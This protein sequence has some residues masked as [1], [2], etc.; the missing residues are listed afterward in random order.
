MGAADL[1]GDEV[2]RVLNFWWTIESLN[3]SEIPKLDAKKH[4]RAIRSEEDWPWKTGRYLPYREGKKEFT[5]RH[6][7]YLGVASSG[8]LVEETFECFKEPIPDIGGRLKSGSTA[9]A[10]LVVDETGSI[11]VSDKATGSDG[12]KSVNKTDRERLA[13]DHSTPPAISPESIVFSTLPWALARLEDLARQVVGEGKSYAA[14]CEEA[15]E[16]IEAQFANSAASVNEAY[17]LTFARAIGILTAW[18]NATK[19]KGTWNEVAR[20]Q[21]IRMRVRDAGEAKK[22]PP[23]L[24]SFFLE[25]LTRV[26]GAFKAGAVGSAL[27]RYIHAPLLSTSEI[28]QRKDVRKFCEHAERWLQPACWT[29][30]A[31]PH[32]G[33]HSLVYAQQCAVNAIWSELGGTNS[34][35]I[36]AVNGP[37]G[38]GKTTLLGDIVAAVVTQRAEVLA[39][40]KTAQAAFEEKIQVTDMLRVYPLIPTLCGHEIVVAS[41]NNSAVENVTRELPVL[42]KVDAGWFAPLE[43]D[44]NRHFAEIATAMLNPLPQAIASEDEG[45]SEEES[46]IKEES[47]EPVE[48]WGL[49]AAVLGNSKNRSA[50]TQTLWFETNPAR[51]FRPFMDQEVKGATRD[52]DTV[53][54]EAQQSFK[55]SLET[56]RSLQTRA[57][58]CATALARYEAKRGELASLELELTHAN[59]DLAAKQSEAVLASENLTL[60]TSRREK[61]VRLREA[62]DLAKTWLKQ[63]DLSTT[64]R[65]QWE[66]ASKAAGAVE[67]QHAHASARVTLANNHADRQRTLRRLHGERKPPFWTFWF[68]RPIAA[69]WGRQAEALDEALWK[70]F[71]DLTELETALAAFQNEMRQVGAAR[72]ESEQKYHI[73][74]RLTE[75]CRRNLDA[76]LLRIPDEVSFRSL[77]QEGSNISKAVE[78]GLLASTVE[79]NIID[80]Q[81]A[82]T[83]QKHTAARAAVTAL[84]AKV[85]ALTEK[86]RIASTDLT[87]SWTV[88]EN[89]RAG[90]VAIDA[91][92]RNSPG[93]V[94]AQQS[95]WIDEEWRKARVKLFLE[96]LA[97]HRAFIRTGWSQ[98]KANLNL[99]TEMLSG[100]LPPG[101][102]RQVPS[103][104]GSVFMI[105]PVVSTT[106]A[107]M[108]RLFRGLQRNGLGWLVIDEAG[109]ATPQMAAGGLWRARRAIV[110]GDPYQITPVVTLPNRLIELLRNKWRVRPGYVPG[111]TSVQRLADEATPWGAIFGVD[112]LWVG[113]PLVVHRRCID[114][115]FEV[116]NEIAYGKAMVHGRK[117]DDS[118]RPLFGASAWVDIDAPATQGNWVENEALLAVDMARHAWHLGENKSIFFITPFRSVADEL[119]DRLSQVLGDKAKDWIKRSVGTVHTFQG[120]ENSSVVLILGGDR[121]KP[122]VRMFPADKPNLL[123]VALTRAKERIYVIGSARFWTEK[124][125]LKILCTA[126]QKKPFGGVVS[127]EQFRQKWI[128]DNRGSING[129][130]VRKS[131]TDAIPGGI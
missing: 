39:N 116:A 5:W 14:L 82:A 2:L 61:Q 98:L 100:R 77:L 101:A 19:W 16:A 127:P 34:E 91:S 63:C 10:V 60:Q 38:T 104:W 25:D 107:S 56:V 79:I 65:E 52:L 96:A 13:P 74:K 117:A 115:M 17:T 47:D 128:Q 40:L 7:V 89:T 36:F 118:F 97:L 20:V 119:K 23:L 57:V 113:C 121:E 67:E 129:N 69:Q 105:T 72:I 49:L 112:D 125:T 85:T 122:G 103:L 88:F 8:R 33:G 29:S 59:A 15:L 53:F 46:Y 93:E 35:G 12:T 32:K 95:P 21:S 131:T 86:R 45:E 123:N 84:Q 120:K 114:P 48:A 22:D 51:G 30:G 4:V 3:F 62:A 92:F 24:N 102:A 9:M 109:Q 68:R 28:S 111:S 27:Q 87:Q 130:G 26:I 75:E 94:Q 64:A 11:F 44:S 18:I 41:A 76:M 43:G 55:R 99:A 110:V 108:D 37:P 71:T 80:Q 66:A 78:Q 58:Q 50:F 54:L 42:T 6:V 70:A 90:R 124:N 106:F 83:Q 126:L 31:W 81:I 73:A 1:V